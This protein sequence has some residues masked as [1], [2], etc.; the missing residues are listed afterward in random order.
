MI[1]TCI[2]LRK[3]RKVTEPS[4]SARYIPSLTDDKFR[5]IHVSILPSLRMTF[6]CDF[7]SPPD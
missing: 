5:E 4:T 2:I 1:Y 6:T 7:I 3:D